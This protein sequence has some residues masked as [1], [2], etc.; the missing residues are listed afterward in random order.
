[1]ERRCIHD[2]FGGWRLAVNS[3]WDGEFRFPSTDGRG[4]QSRGS[5][6]LEVSCDR[7]RTDL[8]VSGLL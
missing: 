5:I 6:G 8:C 4:A 7:S 3:R 2:V 1:M